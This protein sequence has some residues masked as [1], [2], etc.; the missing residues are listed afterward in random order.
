MTNHELSVFEV[1]PWVDPAGINNLTE[2]HSSPPCKSQKQL[3]GFSNHWEYLKV[4]TSAWLLVNMPERKFI[5]NVD[6]DFLQYKVSDSLASN[7][8]NPIVI[9][10]IIYAEKI[11]IRTYTV[12]PTK[13]ETY[14]DRCPI[15][16]LITL[17]SDMWHA[18]CKSYRFFSS[19]KA[20]HEYLIIKMYS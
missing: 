11:S 14:I 18:F 16:S 12:W 15:V 9:G 13:S 1:V 4:K 7:P 3:S 17:I 6:S 19:V 10:T 5:T 2:R 8:Y 20:L